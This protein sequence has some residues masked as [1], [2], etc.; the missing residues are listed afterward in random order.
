[1]AVPFGIAPVRGTPVYQTVLTL[2][3]LA[4]AVVPE[5]FPLVFMLFL[6]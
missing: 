3:G 5:E 4:T 2:I 1:M 6:S